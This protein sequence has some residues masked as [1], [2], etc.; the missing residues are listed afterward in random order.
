MGPRCSLFRAGGNALRAGPAQRFERVMQLEILDTLVLQFIRGELEARVLL[1]V[2]F[3]RLV[4]Q[5]ELVD[6]MP[7]QIAFA[8]GCTCCA[9]QDRGPTAAA[10]R[11]PA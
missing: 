11:Y 4:L 1:G 6:E 8:L 9:W 3:E 10:R 2:G 5:A 7:A